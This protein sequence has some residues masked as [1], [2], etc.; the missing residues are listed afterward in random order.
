MHNRRLVGENEKL[1]KKVSSLK[2]TESPLAGEAHSA[3][4]ERQKKVCFY[5]LSQDMSLNNN[6]PWYHCVDGEIC[7]V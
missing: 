7:L 6:I 3:G 5:N 2:K 1:L 4:G